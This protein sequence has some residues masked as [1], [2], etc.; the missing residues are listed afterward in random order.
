MNPSFGGWYGRCIETCMDPRR[1]LGGAA[2]TRGGITGVPVAGSVP[3]GRTVPGGSGAGGGANTFVTPRSSMTPN[4]TVAAPTRT[5]TMV[6]VLF[7]PPS[8][9]GEEASVC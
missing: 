5:S 8:A 9:G 6:P 4:A 2:G 3:G 7:F 1:Y